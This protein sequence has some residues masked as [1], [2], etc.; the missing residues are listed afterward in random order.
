M[1]GL[2]FD[3]GVVTYGRQAEDELNYSEL[4]CDVHTHQ[5]LHELIAARQDHTWQF[6]R[7]LALCHT[8]ASVQSPDGIVLVH[9]LSS[10]CTTTS[11]LRS[12]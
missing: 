5:R 10:R 12:R 7:L 11:R 4:S 9:S 1:G 2:W 3:C 6:F 8:V